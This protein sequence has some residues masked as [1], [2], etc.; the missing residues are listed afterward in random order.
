MDVG[1]AISHNPAGTPNKFDVGAHTPYITDGFVAASW[2]R[3]PAG[4]VHMVS[5]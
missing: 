3:K 5:A 1:T 2:G 4:P